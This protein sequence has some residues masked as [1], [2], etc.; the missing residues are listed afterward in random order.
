MPSG[1]EV[2]RDGTIGG[3]EALG[4]PWGF[5]PPHPS[6]PLARRLVGV[7]RSIVQVSVLS[8]LDPGH[9][10][11]FRDTMA[12]QLT[13]DEHPGHVRQA[14]EELVEERLS[15]LLVPPTLHQDIKDISILIDGTPWIMALTIDR[16][17]LL[18]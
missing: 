7:F 15:R 5:A 17:T 6:L 2:L 13:R 8:R 12:S 1:S 16:Q 3:E 4:L 18:V 11:P 9:D 14:L 10:F